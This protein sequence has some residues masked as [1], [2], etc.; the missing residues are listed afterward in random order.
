MDGRHAV[1]PRA[2]GDSTTPIFLA[3]YLIILAFFVLLNAISQRQEA[4]SKAVLGSLGTTFSQSALIATGPLDFASGSGVFT[5]VGDFEETMR[6]LFQAAFPFVKVT[7]YQ[8]FG[9]L[10]VE[11][12]VESIFS[13][14]GTGPLAEQAPFFDR[15][16]AALNR[17][18][19]DQ[20]FEVQLLIALSPE[21]ARNATRE[22]ATAVTRAGAFAR[23]LDE[24][25][26][27]ADH[28]SVGIEEG[29][30]AMLRLLFIAR[31]ADEGAM[32]HGAG[33]E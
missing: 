30:P 15:L 24:R 13:P 27:P 9:Q 21:Q 8:P 26:V 2:G 18:I 20:Y 29:D 5:A 16:A 10:Q 33:G 14:D 6:A 19:P 22:R 1:K 32:S 11:F 31:Q 12:P 7:P 4:R 17:E 25:G 28:V 3:L 23:A